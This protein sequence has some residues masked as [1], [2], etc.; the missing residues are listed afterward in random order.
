MHPVFSPLAIMTL[1]SVVLVGCSLTPR[2]TE[3]PTWL[4][5]LERV[6]GNLLPGQIIEMNDQRPIAFQQLLDR[7]SNKRLV[8]VGETHNMQKI[9]D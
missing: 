2:R 5:Q 1:V 4:V 7:L 6:H 8:Y 9:R 3:R